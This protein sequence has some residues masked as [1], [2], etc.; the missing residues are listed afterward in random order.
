MAG[1]I[2]QRRRVQRIAQR[3]SR[4]WCAPAIFPARRSCPSALAGRAGDSPSRRRMAPSAFACE[5][6]I[7]RP[8]SPHARSWSSSLT[9]ARSSSEIVV[10]LRRAVALSRGRGRLRGRCRLD[11][12]P[13]HAVRARGAVGVAAIGEREHRA[14]ARDVRPH[15]G[16]DR[17]RECLEAGVLVLLRGIGRG[18][19]HPRL[20]EIGQRL[21]PLPCRVGPR[22][23]ERRAVERIDAPRDRLP[24]APDEQDRLAREPPRG[25]ARGQALAGGTLPVDRE[26]GDPGQPRPDLRDVDRRALRHRRTARRR[27]R[28]GRWRGQ[29]CPR[30]RA[31]RRSARRFAGVRRR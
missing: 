31:R 24:G 3:P 2:P 5:G 10:G 17:G 11:R 19:P 14:L 1:W 27:R 22:V 12:G 7:S 29:G 18:P 26:R 13:R 4:S 25:E 20:S 23:A 15:L 30:R 16:R 8:G 28:P 21:E 9:R 6:V